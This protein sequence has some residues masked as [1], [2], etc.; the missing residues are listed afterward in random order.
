[1][2]LATLACI[3][4]GGFA[5]ANP[6]FEPLVASTSSVFMRVSM[7]KGSEKGSFLDGGILEAYE[8]S[9]C[10]EHLFRQ[11]NRMLP[12]RSQ[13]AYGIPDERIAGMPCWM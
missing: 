2:G 8:V 4:L 9:H 3:S 10:L 11:A 1:V 6:D 7:Q 13:R 12:P 5:D